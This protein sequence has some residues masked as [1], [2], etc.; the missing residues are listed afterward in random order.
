MLSS[1]MALFALS[2]TS[3]EVYWLDVTARVV[4]VNPAALQALGYRYE[5][6]VGLH[7]ADFVPEMGPERWAVLL[8]TVRRDGEV[9]LETTQLRSDGVTYPVEISFALFLQEGGDLI[10]GMVRDVSDRKQRERRSLED[11]ARYRDAMDVPGLG[12][13]A[14]N[15]N[16][17]IVDANTTYATMSGYAREALIGMSAALLEVNQDQHEA[18]TIVDRAKAE[19]AILFRSRHRRA[20][21]TVW[22]VEVAVKYSPI[23]G[24]TVF[25]FIMD[26]GERVTNEQQLAEKSRQ[27]ETLLVQHRE[28]QEIAKVGHYVYDIVQDSWCGSD[29]LETMFG[30]GPN[31]DHSVAGW[32]SLVH[33]DDQGEM[34]A[35]LKDR[36][37]AG[38]ERFDKLYRIIDQMT[39]KVKWV[40][41]KGH[42]HRDETGNPLEMFG[43]IQDV[44]DLKQ[45]EAALRASERLKRQIFASI[46]DLVFLKDAAGRYLACNPVFERLYNKREAELLGKDDFAFIDPDTAEF[47]RRHD[48]QAMAAGRP[49]INEEWLTFADTGRRVL[50]ETVKTPMLDEEG[51]IIGVLGLSRDITERKQIEDT[52]R[53]TNEE[54][55]QSNEDLESFAYVASHDLREPLRTVTSFSTLL[56]RSLGEDLTPDQKDYLEFVHKGATRMDRLIRDLV[57]YSRI[58]RSANP[59]IDLSVAKVVDT[60]LGQL[61]RQLEEEGARVTRCHGM[62]RVYACRGEVERLFLNLITNALKYRAPDRSPEINITCALQGDRWEFCISDNGIGMDLEQYGAGRIFRLFQRLHGRDEYGGG[63]GVGLSV[64]KKIVEHYGGRVWV[65]STP[66]EGSQFFFT[67]PQAATR[68]DRPKAKSLAPHLTPSMT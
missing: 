67:L 39:G 58:G 51:R 4:D 20:D 6:L 66:G 37:L 32:L 28:A 18:Q 2:K 60:V 61:R 15:L 45:I 62:P 46:P 64:C 3:M 43:T 42:L 8:D 5:G 34:Q 27:L 40:H 41:G 9:L 21:G 50:V 30:I 13:L 25:A 7:L 52:L 38:G 55:R 68:E 53:E 12:F 26:I 14:V 19:G 36:V 35:Y 59:R 10:C 65:K 33:P 49:Q 29:V 1:D 23:D 22:P 54:L 17:R 31:F 47:F 48:R 57:E 63:T 16:S 11:L 24:G 44:T 56:K